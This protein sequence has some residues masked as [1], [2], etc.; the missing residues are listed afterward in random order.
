MVVKDGVIMKEKTKKALKVFGI[1]ATVA[2][3][4]YIT[5]GN[6]FYY[7]TLTKKG[8]NSSFADKFASP[9]KDGQEYKEHLN[10]ILDIGK[11]WFDSANKEKVIIRSTNFNKNI[12]ADYIF[13]KQPSN[14]YV[15]LI[16]G[17]T[18]SPRNMGIYAE[19]YHNIGYNVILPSLNGH[20]DSETNT[21]TMGWND[22][23]DIIDLINSI[24]ENN[25]DAKIIIHGV[26][27]GA[28]TTMMT[29]GENLPENVKVAVADCGYTSVWDIFS[30]KLNNSMH[31]PDFPILYSA[32][33][34]NKSIKK[35]DFKKASSVE[36]LRKSK[37]PTIFIHGEKDTFVPYAMLD[38][39]YN[40]CTAPKEKVTIPNAPH[41][42]N[43]CADPDLYWNSVLN[44]IKDYI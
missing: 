10:S 42:R 32:N 27:M 39:V 4:V 22:R 36:Q 28:A 38:E 41:A 20:G 6:V 9:N 29:T 33:E 34:V 5:I 18:S 40:A 25:P 26:S 43:S 17:Y 3:A 2:G 1:T 21:V 12:H 44:F 8:L 16:H 35:F 30:D 31:L 15:I 23:L 7:M 24:L 11:K 19:K 13:A 37:T 14:V